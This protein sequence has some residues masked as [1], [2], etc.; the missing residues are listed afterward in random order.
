MKTHFCMVAGSGVDHERGAYGLKV[1]EL[2]IFLLGW[3]DKSVG[4]E[5]QGVEL[6]KT[7]WRDAFVTGS[8]EAKLQMV[9]TSFNQEEQFQKSPPR[10]FFSPSPT[11]FVL[12]ICTTQRPQLPQVL[13]QVEVGE[14]RYFVFC[15]NQSSQKLSLWQTVLQ[16]P[17]TPGNDCWSG[18]T[19]LY[20]RDI[21][22]LQAR[23]YTDRR[24]L[25]AFDPKGLI[26]LLFPKKWDVSDS[27]CWTVGK[28]NQ[29]CRILQMWIE[30]MFLWTLVSRFSHLFIAFIAFSASQGTSRRCFSV[31]WR[32]AHQKLLPR[33]P[34]AMW[35]WLWR[36]STMRPMLR[37]ATRRGPRV[38]QSVAL[39]I[40]RFDAGDHVADQV[41]SLHSLFLHFHLNTFI[42][43]IIIYNYIV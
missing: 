24:L 18:R 7:L 28:E 37:R 17:E 21:V 9:W 43:Y 34:W 30:C 5:H 39:S 12:G 42:I 1:P 33:W 29:V 41:F 2:Q 38:S 6:G 35:T 14:N 25:D 13:N 10:T 3:H 15:R 40:S 32:A 22:A 26:N 20:K 19:Q 23:F 8:A 27:K 31:W 11:Q 16:I 36:R 4:R